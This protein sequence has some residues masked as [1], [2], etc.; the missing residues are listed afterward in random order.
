MSD[1]INLLGAEDVRSAGHRMAEA[2]QKMSEA[3]SSMDYTVEKLR[4]ILDDFLGRFEEIVNK[5]APE[6]GTEE[7]R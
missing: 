3:A 6:K 1:F 4:G 2:A 5:P 7:E